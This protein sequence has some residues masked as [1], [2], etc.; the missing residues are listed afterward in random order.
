[1]LLVGK[2]RA[3]VMQCGAC[4]VL[5]GAVNAGK[6]SLLNALLGRERALVTDIPGTT[7]DFLEEPCTLEGLPVRLVDTAGLRHAGADTEDAVEHMGMALS[8]EK[9]SQADA[10]LLVLDGASLGEAGALAAHCPDAVAA[11][12]LELAENTP[13]IVVWNKSDVCRPGHFPPLWAQGRPAV[14]ISARSGENVDGLARL[15]RETILADGGNAPA[16]GLAPNARQAL[17]LEGALE[18]LEALLTDLNAGQPYDCCTVRLDTAAARL[19][20]VTGLASPA[21]VLDSVFAQFC[22][23]K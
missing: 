21:E 11:Q 20:E 10:V 2:E 8:R 7:R 9:L 13:L 14:C 16:D 22:I 1:R 23:G 5:A 12:I 18:E 19:G 17:A 6:S 15:L 3:R 4:V